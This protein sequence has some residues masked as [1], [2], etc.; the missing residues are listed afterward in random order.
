MPTHYSAHPLT[1][2][3]RMPPS[4]AQA[5]LAAQKPKSDEP[6]QLTSHSTTRS[7]AS[8]Y[9]RP[10]RRVGSFRKDE[11]ERLKASVLLGQRGGTDSPPLLSFHSSNTA[12]GVGG[13]SGKQSG[14]EGCSAC[15]WP[16]Q[17]CT[18]STCPTSL[19]KWR[20]GG[21]LRPP[22]IPLPPPPQTCRLTGRH[23]T[24][25]PKAGAASRHHLL[26]F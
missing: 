18:G 1:C 8:A 22:G 9:I 3:G 2:E 19:V 10:S 15:W 4:L 24:I 14:R 16:E 7:S 26:S 5:G 20:A 25:R 6:N 13:C 17:L 12:N 21:A 11:E 23:C